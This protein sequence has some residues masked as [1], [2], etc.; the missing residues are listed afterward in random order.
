MYIGFFRK[1]YL[2]F[3]LLKFHNV[4]CIS[5]RWATPQNYTTVGAH[6]LRNFRDQ[7]DL[8]LEGDVSFKKIF[9]LYDSNYYLNMYFLIY[10]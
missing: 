3:K 8:L 10:I 6:V 2:Y 4:T 5:Y 7:L 1:N 9:F